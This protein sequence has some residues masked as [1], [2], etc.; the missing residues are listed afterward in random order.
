[1]LAV[2]GGYDR[3]LIDNIRVYA[4][5]SKSFNGSSK[6]API[7]GTLGVRWDR[8]TDF[9]SSGPDEKTS[10]ASAFAGVEVPLT[11]DGALSLI[12]E[13]QS[14]NIG[15]PLTASSD[16]KFPYSL[17]LR[18]HP[19]NQAFSIGAGVARQGLNT[20]YESQPRFFVQAGYTFGK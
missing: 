20:P 12:G 14:K 9:S 13:L 2:G 15:D 11:R 17:G 18:Y 6:R 1:L 3:G 5:A 7:I 8:Y 16:A 4:A 19:R 10:K